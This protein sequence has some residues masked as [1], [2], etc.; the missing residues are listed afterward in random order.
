LGF[1]K[2]TFRLIT[3]TTRQSGPEKGYRKLLVSVRTKDRNFRKQ[4]II[5][6]NKGRFLENK[7]SFFLLFFVK[8]PCF[9]EQLCGFCYNWVWYVQEKMLGYVNIKSIN[10]RKE[11]TVARNDSQ[12]VRF[13]VVTFL[14]YSPSLKQSKHQV[15]KKT[16]FAIAKKN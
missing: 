5:R 13:R 14:A 9:K 11:L 4:G 3:N 12:E 16:T 10:A 7:P 15:G 2:V 6:R 8:E 1:K